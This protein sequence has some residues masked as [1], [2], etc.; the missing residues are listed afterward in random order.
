MKNFHELIDRC[1]VLVVLV[2]WP[3]AS[4]CQEQRFVSEINP[5]EKVKVY[6]YTNDSLLKKHY[7]LDGL[8]IKVEYYVD[9]L[10]I[11]SQEYIYEW[12]TVDIEVVDT[13]LNARIW[14][15]IIVPVK[16]YELRYYENEQIESMG[17]YEVIFS[18]DYKERSLRKIGQWLLW[19][20]NGKLIKVEYLGG[21]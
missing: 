11:V 16:Y 4:I 1:L 12:D 3:F 9:S 14:E 18:D 19:D 5:D 10:Q 8:R 15:T 6:T 17:G 21:E 7:V 2:I 20:E 13:F